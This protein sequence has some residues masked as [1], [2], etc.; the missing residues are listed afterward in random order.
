MVPKNRQVRKK[1]NIIFIHADKVQMEKVREVAPAHL[2]YKFW[3]KL[4]MDGIL[5]EGYQNI[6]RGGRALVYLDGVRLNI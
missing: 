6:Q 2:G 5:K 3:K 4:G 1:D